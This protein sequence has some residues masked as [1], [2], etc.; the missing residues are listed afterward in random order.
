MVNLMK[1][2]D[3]EEQ[4]EKYLTRVLFFAASSGT[5]IFTL[6]WSI[7]NL[8]LPSTKSNILFFILLMISI[9]ASVGSIL[10][11]MS[12]YYNIV[13]AIKNAND[14]LKLLNIQQENEYTYSKTLWV[15]PLVSFIY[16]FIYLVMLIVFNHRCNYIK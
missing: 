13:N 7:Y 1:K 8:I 16:L 3:V 2:G 4:D 14:K 6:A 12:V 11:N 10:T 5:F 15:F 9:I